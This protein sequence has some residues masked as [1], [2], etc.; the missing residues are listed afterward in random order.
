MMLNQNW[1]YLVKED[2]ED[3]KDKVKHFKGERLNFDGYV[4]TNANGDVVFYV[5]SEN[6]MKYGVEVFN[7]K[8][9]K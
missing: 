5:N 4:V 6:Y 2:F 3:G 7:G 1:Y 8:E 9:I